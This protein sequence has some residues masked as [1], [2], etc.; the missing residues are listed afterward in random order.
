MKLRSKELGDKNIVGSNI[1]SI[2][3]KLGIKQKEYL[4]RLHVLELDISPTM[5]SRIEGQHR[6]VHDFE[7]V[8]L[9]KA[10]GVTP[11]DLLNN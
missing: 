2:R 4:A 3:R 7:V 9:A 8:A 11:N 10:L 6:L 5:L 1:I